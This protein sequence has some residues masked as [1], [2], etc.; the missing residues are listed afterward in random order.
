MGD[1]SKREILKDRVVNLVK[2]F[3]KAEGGISP[4][5]VQA[6]FGPPLL[7][8]EVATALGQLPIRYDV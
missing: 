8:S 2:Q 7:N 1:L 4:N 6:L 5:D 3:I